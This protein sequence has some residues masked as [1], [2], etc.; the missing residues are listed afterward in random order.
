[1]LNKLN[2]D[3]SFVKDGV[4]FQGVGSRCSRNEDGITFFDMKGI[5]AAVIRNIGLPFGAQQ[6]LGAL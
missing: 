3:R 2:R 4:T 6:D 1:M 5:V